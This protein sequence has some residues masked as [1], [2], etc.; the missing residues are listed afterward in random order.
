MDINSISRLHKLIRIAEEGEA[1]STA[2]TTADLGTVPNPGVPVK[3]RKKKVVKEAGYNWHAGMS[4]NAVTAYNNG[5]KPLSKWKKS[6]IINAI[7]DIEISDYE[8]KEFNYTEAGKEA[9]IEHIQKLP[10]IKLRKMLDQSS[11][12]HTGKY[13]N[14]TYFYKMPDNLGDI[15]AYA[16]YYDLI[17][18]QD[19]F[20]K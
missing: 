10:L 13:Y 16:E 5:E 3:R 18:D 7:K 8:K 4:N 17:D 9:F 6:D 14:L 19:D 1:Y 15:L 20:M 12:H 11:Y 2:G